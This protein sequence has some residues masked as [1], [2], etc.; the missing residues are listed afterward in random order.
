MAESKS[1]YTIALEV[2]AG[3]WGNGVERRNKITAAGYSF[4]DVQSIVNSLVKDGYLK[5]PPA[6]QPKQAEPA[7]PSKPLEIDFDPEKNNGIIVNII[8]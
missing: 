8:V 2:L 3:K 1:N 6:E 7:E 4:D 5:N